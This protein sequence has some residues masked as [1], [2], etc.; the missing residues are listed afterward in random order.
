MHDMKFITSMILIS[1]AIAIPGAIQK[2][3]T[4]TYRVVLDPGHGG[5]SSSKLS[6]H[7]DRYD[8][9][10]ERYLAP[11]AEG[12]AHRGLWE[13]ILVYQI[14]EKTRKILQL[15]SPAG[16]FRKFRTLLARYT[17]E[18][19]DRIYIETFMSR[20]DSSDRE[21]I[22]HR[23]DPNSEFRLYDY[24]DGKGNILPGRISRINAVKPHLVVCLHMTW[25][26]S[27]TYRGMNPVIV[28]PHSVLYDGLLYIQKKKSG[29]D[30]FEKGLYSHWFME[31]D[32]RSVFKWFLN[33]SVFYFLG[34]PLT[35]HGA[36]DHKKFRGYR[37]NMVHWAYR[38]GPGWE[39]TARLHPENGPYAK[40][41][42]G[43]VPGGKFWEREKSV[44]EAYR[45]D[46]GEEGYGGDNM[47][48]TSELIRYIL[49]SLEL[50]G[51]D[52]PHQRLTEPYISTWSVPLLVNAVTAFIE[53][54]SLANTRHRY[55]FQHKQD[56][57]AEG[58]A[59]GI[60]SLLSGLKLKKN[61]YHWKPRG[62]KIDFERYLLPDGTSYF[63]AV[64]K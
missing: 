36:V 18:D 32:R 23:A 10:S 54:G 59:V 30:F 5:I 15:C 55:L 9:I 1:L 24:P 45:R 57:I 19:P 7:G 61:T 37:Y 58:L 17:D 34:Y 49:H 52:H 13:H 46:K 25:D 3:A 20:G 38:D 56:E 29:R 16:D 60:Y 63:D 39:K 27:A 44:Y 4:P 53:L 42:S 28:P 8:Q 33:D 35:R 31:S 2:A 11:F 41:I 51:Q 48:A 43:F 22:S 26:Y 62:R 12:A 6:V 21:K 14:A 40:T 50:S 47:Y 64:V